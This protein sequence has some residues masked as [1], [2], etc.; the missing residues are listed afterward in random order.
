MNIFWREMKS[1]LKSIIIWSIAM[2]SIIAVSIGKYA[3]LSASEI[4]LNEIVAKMPKA[5]QTMMGGAAFDFSKASG[6]YGAIFGY[7]LLI[8]T[9]HAAMLGANILAKEE[10]DKTA[11]FLLS[12]PIT[13]GTIVGSKL[14]SALCN[15]VI[16][17]LVTWGMSVMIM[18]AFGE[19]EQVT[20]EIT[21]L[22]AGMLILQL[23][24]F[25]LGFV[26]SAVFAQ[27]KRASGITVAVLLLTYL[28][29]FMID[30]SDSL[31]GLA[32]LTP[33]KY[34][35][36]AAILGGGG[37]DGVYVIVSLALSALFIAMTF[38][39]YQKRDLNL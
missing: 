38:V 22:M 24:F 30:L 29:S 4:S 36:T 39:F 31:S 28:L 37:L 9:I 16:L 34:F 1:N 18:K 13:R 26:L 33:F 15:I 17:T 5:L 23:L 11:E 27:A 19:N 20:A 32:F 2:L 25:S 12:K 7:L 8:A 14:A 10:R 21:I 35:D 6:F 3:G